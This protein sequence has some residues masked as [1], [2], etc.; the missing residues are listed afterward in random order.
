[1]VN[2]QVGFPFLKLISIRRRGKCDDVSGPDPLGFGCAGGARAAMVA[3]PGRG[4][5]GRG[6][7]G[8]W[9]VHEGAGRRRLAG[10]EDGGRV[11]PQAR[12]A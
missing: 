2:K 10:G 9:Q 3:V 6:G 12:P 7:G 8:S 1:L 11:W 4:V 5:G